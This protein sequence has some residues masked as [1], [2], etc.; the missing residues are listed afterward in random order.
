MAFFSSA[1]T[2][3]TF[4]ARPAATPGQIN[5]SAASKTTGDQD[6]E[7]TPGATDT[8]S[9]LAF[10]PT[11][12][13]LAVASWDNNVRIY[14]IN[15]TSPTPVQP[16]QQYSHEGPVL[17]LCWSTDGSKVFSAGADKVC[18]MFDMNTNQPAVVAQHNDTIRSVRW[19]N[20]AGGVLLTAGW[21]KQLK[22]WKIDNPASPQAVHSLT[23]P[24]KCYAMDNV[25]NVVVVAM[26]E[27]MVLGF[28]LEETGSITPLT[29]QQSPLKYQTRSMAVLPDGDGYALGGVEGR[30]GVQYF[31]DPPDK[32]NKV[33]KFA[34]KCHRR[35]NADHPEVPRNESHIYP[36]NC[37]AFNVHGTFATGGADG[38]INF[39]C[40][41]SRTR[42]KTME[43]KGP[44]N[45]PK[46]LLKTNPAKQPITAIG[47]N[48]DA[49]IF[50]YAV[51][52]DW[53]KGYQGAG[54]V[55][56]KIYIQPVKY[57][58][59]QKRPPKA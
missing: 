44:A 14:Q 23:L 24:E 33:K 28:R 55:E 20:V 50:A 10:S 1:S 39:W 21:D 51:G 7:V 47:F 58:D 57:E 48:R 6:Q 16:W 15:K 42:L 4:G 46:E 35:A 43:T 27:R 12:D 38:S 56:P 9:A 8:V 31:H 29:E 26:A 17:D 2:T 11:A 25:Q 54:Q 41:Q 18:R 52:Y 53:H 32:D 34:F 59:V 37:I 19:L 22:I 13:F 40:K 36:V 5:T 49:T 45:A 30:V 3:N